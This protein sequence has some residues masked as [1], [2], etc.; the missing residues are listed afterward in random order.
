MLGGL[1]I[2]LLSLAGGLVGG[3]VV[4][5]FTAKMDQEKQRNE[6]MLAGLT[7]DHEI[8]MDVMEGPKRGWKGFQWTRRVIALTIVFMVFVFPKVMYVIFDTPVIY[9]WSEHTPDFLFFDGSVIQHWTVLKGI[10]IT[11]IDT[12][13]AMAIIGLYFGK[14]K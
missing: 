14:G 5:F 10:P 3:L 7:K 12:H 9:A 13:A 6:I 8:R 1:P 11:P 4:K 2:E